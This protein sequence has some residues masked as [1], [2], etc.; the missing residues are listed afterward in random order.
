MAE[1]QPN[2][3]T[4]ETDAER[5]DRHEGLQ[6]AIEALDAVNRAAGKEGTQ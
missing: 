5:T 6:A 1:P 4:P 2:N 3:P